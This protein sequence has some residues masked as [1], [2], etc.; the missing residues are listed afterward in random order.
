MYSL[1]AQQ[2]IHVLRKELDKMGRGSAKIYV[3]VPIGTGNILFG[4]VRGMERFGARRAK[5]VAAVPYDD[6]M[7]KPFLPK[8]KESNGGPSMKRTLSLAP[9]LTGFYSPL[10]PCL[11][12]L[13]EEKGFENPNTVEFIEVDRAAQLE[14]AA[15]VSGPDDT[16]TID[17][18]PSAL[19]A[20]GALKELARLIQVHGEKEDLKN[21]VALVVN[22]GRG[23]M[24]VKEKEFYETSILA[25]R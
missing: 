25:S 2:C 9:K 7:M 19:I 24:D 16:K 10:S 18:E 22:S 11:W 6:H 5:I 12:H 14:V 8:K 1:L 20:F 4:F 15:R 23:I 3:I 17:A 13:T 21:S